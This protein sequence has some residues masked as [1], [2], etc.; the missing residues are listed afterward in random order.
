MDIKSVRIIGIKIK[1][2]KNVEYGGIEFNGASKNYMASVLGLYGQNGS[3]KTALLDALELLKSLIS[4]TRVPDKFSDYINVETEESEFEFLFELS[5]D[6]DIT[7]ASYEFS[8]KG[9]DDDS[10]GNL[11]SQSRNVKKRTLIFDEILKCSIMSSSQS[12][13]GRLIDTIDCDIFTP[14]SKKQLLVG[15]N[16]ENDMNLV[17]AKRLCQEQS[18]SFIFS[19]ELLDVIRENV[20]TL[21][22]N[23]E[24]DFYHS[25]IE[26]LAYFGNRCLFIVNTVTSGLISLNA[27]PISFKYIQNNRD[28]ALGTMAL[29]LYEPAFIPEYQL[30][31]ILKVI[32]NMNIVLSKLIPGLKISVNDLGRQTMGNGT[33]AHR[34][35]LMS[36]KNKKAIPLKYESEGIKKIV[37]V[38]QLLIVVYNNPSVTVAV[39]ELDS[40]IFEYLL[41]E[42][43]RILSEKGKGQ[44][45]FTS[46]NLRPLETID[47]GFV[48]FTTTNPKN[49][50]IRPVNVK[51]TNNL[52]DLY[53]RDIMLSSNSEKLYDSTKNTEIAL[54]FKE[55]GEICAE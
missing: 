2:F 23:L 55:A 22:E 35:E 1:N 20:K 34:I 19:R 31:I 48:A 38:L 41:G 29:P 50:Y 18:R 5:D 8:M 39:D 9:V 16:R 6:K 3:G 46:H 30:N 4:G 26:S 47:K 27:Q 40:G 10:S 54:A 45:I 25:V 28:M 15:N 51:S 14:V 43:L 53:Y 44:L 21:N 7:L 36:L 24:A 17:I 37:S 11:I 32:D 12:R 33:V 52:R 42:I 49:R 13:Q